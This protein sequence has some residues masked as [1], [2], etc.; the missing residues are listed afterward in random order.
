MKGYIA[1]NFFPQELAVIGIENPENDRHSRLIA[2][3]KKAYSAASLF[4]RIYFQSHLIVHLS[5]K[6]IYVELSLHY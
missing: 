6:V 1:E 2:Y 5:V 3:R 4:Y